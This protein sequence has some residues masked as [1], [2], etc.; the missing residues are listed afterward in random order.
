M[1]A[2][3]QTVSPV[4]PKFDLEALLR[5]QREN[6]ETWFQAQKIL[7]DFSTALG[8]RQAALFEEAIARAEELMK[9]LD[10]KKQPASY[11][12]E[13]KAALEKAVGQ[14]RET[15]D[16]GLKT[17]S[18]VVELLVKRAAANLDEMRKLAA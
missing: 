5:L 18:Q 8:K 3:A 17:Q 4:L 15:V 7:F 13:A 10:P 9:G 1:S 2:K 11:A 14:I 12:E 16:L 6:L